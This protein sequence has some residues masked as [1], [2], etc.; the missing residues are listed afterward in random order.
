[1]EVLSPEGITSLPTPIKICT[2]WPIVVE[3]SL[4]L[5]ELF[6]VSADTGR[7][8]RVLLTQGAEALV[9]CDEVRGCGHDPQRHRT[10]AG[11]CYGC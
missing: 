11:A 9:F 3:A 5:G 6:G 1:V 2:G 10:D 4:S 7:E 8:C